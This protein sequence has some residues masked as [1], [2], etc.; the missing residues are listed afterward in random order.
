[1]IA[2]AGK[3]A[4][5]GLHAWLPNAIEAPTPVSALIHAATLVTA[6]VYLLMRLAPL[7][8]GSTSLVCQLLGMVSL[9]YAGF[10]GLTQTDAKR[11]IA[12]STISQIGYMVL[13]C[14]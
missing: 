14:G 7:L 6:G 9:I 3:S 5:L 13:G 10:V 8:E 4:Q 11:V 2:V 12:F 1:L